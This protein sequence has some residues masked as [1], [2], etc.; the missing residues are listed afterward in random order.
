[1]RTK[2]KLILLTCI[3]LTQFS[4]VSKKKYY[5]LQGTYDM[6]NA[7]SNYEPIIQKDDR[8]YIEV[9][10]YQRELSEP[11]NFNSLNTGGISSGGNNPLIGYLVDSE[12]YIDFPV[13]GKVSVA[14]FTV[15]QLRLYLS[16]K[17][18]TY[19]VDPKINIRIL[20][21]KVTV[22]GAVNNPGVV[23]FTSNRATLLDALAQAGDL[24]TY[25]IRNN[26]M[27]VRD[28]QGIKSF[29]TIDISK[30]DFV[31]SPYYY[32]DQNDFI[33]VQ[34]RR[35]KVD[36]SA[37]PNLPLFVSILSFLTTVTLLLTR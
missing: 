26:I 1:M 7:S 37:L 24:T 8:I 4:C 12:G 17:L 22:L 13:L 31:N 14:G 3:A 36:A 30:A 33:Y 5:L 19:L 23:S 11:F 21:F 32:L 28:Y 29:H 9:M 20:N 18:K 27:I 6:K 35:A 15:E 34:E 16:D 25:G 2:I 10:T